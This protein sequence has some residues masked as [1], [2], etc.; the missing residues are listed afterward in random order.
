MENNSSECGL[1]GASRNI[2]SLD[3]LK[4]DPG[5]PVWRFGHQNTQLTEI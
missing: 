3:T 4:C 5:S 1:C 2:L